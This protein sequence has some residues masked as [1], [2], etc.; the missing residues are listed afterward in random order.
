M[1]IDFGINCETLLNI[2]TYF[3]NLELFKDNNKLQSLIIELSNYINRSEIELFYNQLKTEVENSLELSTNY[4]FECFG[5]RIKYERL[6]QQGL[7][8]ELGMIA[9]E[10]SYIC[11]DRMLIITGHGA[12]GDSGL[13]HK[14]ATR[15]IENPKVVL[16]LRHKKEIDL[17]ELIKLA[18][19]HTDNIITDIDLNDYKKPTKPNKRHKKW[20]SLYKFHK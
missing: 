15:L 10:F 14:I 8:T 13:S 9:E 7:I 19:K 12:D 17:N 20:Q 3:S 4:I 6:K 2:P 5:N 1:D 11:K 18:K 16:I